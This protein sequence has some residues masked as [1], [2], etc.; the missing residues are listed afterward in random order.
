MVADSA[1]QCAVL[2]CGPGAQTAVPVVPN[3]PAAPALQA[4]FSG[5]AGSA[6][7]AACVGT[8]LLCGTC[9]AATRGTGVEEATGD[10]GGQAESFTL[11][12]TDF[13]RVFEQRE[14]GHA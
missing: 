14:F 9:S 2:S 6:S 11:P 3:L 13:L 10:R 1:T 8:W 7:G 5:N 12:T 4:G